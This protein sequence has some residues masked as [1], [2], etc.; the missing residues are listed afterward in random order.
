MANLFQSQQ[1][2][3]KGCK[4]I[5]LFNRHDS[6]LH[7]S[8][9][10]CCQAKPFGTK[11]SAWLCMG[12]SEAATEYWIYLCEWIQECI[13][14]TMLISHLGFRCSLCTGY[15]SLHRESSPECHT[16]ECAPVDLCRR[17]QTT[18]SRPSS[19]LHGQTFINTCFR[20]AEGLARPWLSGPHTLHQSPKS[21]SKQSPRRHFRRNGNHGVY[22]GQTFR[23]TWICTLQELNQQIFFKSFW[24]V[25]TLAVTNLMMPFQLHG[26]FSFINR[27]GRDCSIRCYVKNP[28]LMQPKL[29]QGFYRYFG[30][31]NPLPFPF[32]ND[33]KQC[34]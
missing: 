14:K 8:K 22:L 6:E 18:Q 9:W 23:K 7:N 17:T 12:F 34:G 19:H 2:I 31:C 28:H 29:V 4:N 10:S 33:A 11:K 25:G 30:K 3:L 27:A 15:C 1:W 32:N 16:L 21:T 26:N 13:C 24:V 20:R 5:W